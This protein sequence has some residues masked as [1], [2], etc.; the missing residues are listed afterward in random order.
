MIVSTNRNPLIALGAACAIVALAGCGGGPQ[1]SVPGAIDTGTFPN[2]NIPPQSAA[3]PI[4][5][6]EKAAMYGQIGAAHNSQAQA[7]N[8]S[9]PHANPLLLKKIAND[10]GKETLKQIEQQ[11]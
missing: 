1:T 8:A 2:L 3:E 9:A 7:A 4:S 6:G 10:H 5:A 11:R